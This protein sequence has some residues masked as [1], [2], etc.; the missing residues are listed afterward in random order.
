[1]CAGLGV[2]TCQKVG[3]VAVDLGFSLDISTDLSWTSESSNSVTLE[4]TYSYTT[5]DSAD[6]PSKLG[7][8]FLTPSLN[9]KFSKSALISFDPINCA[10]ASKEIITWSLD[11]P[12]NV[13]V[14]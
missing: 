3:K 14:S 2:A 11:S 1:M 9:V 10:G 13:P 5:S 4:F 6:I 7:D 12:S 8:M